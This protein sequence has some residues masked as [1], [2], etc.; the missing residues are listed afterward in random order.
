MA[1]RE[2]ERYTERNRAQRRPAGEGA[3]EGGS[4][5]QNPA[6]IMALAGLV[7]A[8]A[9]AVGF[10]VGRDK[11][12]TDT[13][14]SPDAAAT[15]AAAVTE[16]DPAG[17]DA[18]A[19]PTGADAGGEDGATGAEPAPAAGGTSDRANKY[20]APANQALDP[21]NTAY[22]AT[23][24]TD[25][26]DIELQLF[27][28]VAPKHVN[29]FVFLARQGFYD[30]LAF[31]RVEPGFVIQGGDPLGTGSGGPGYSIPAEFNSD[32]P[33]PHR[34]GTLAMARSGDPNSGGSQFYIVLA[35]GPAPT[36]LDGQYTNFGH[37]I[38][39]MDTVLAIQRGDLMN[40][41]TI[42][43]KPIAESVVTADDIRAGNL[44]E[45]LE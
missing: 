3:P 28:D 21:E 2:R 4:S 35:D 17:E 19:D 5:M 42:T 6:V 11:G 34:I 29:A 36:S 20:D 18:A 45:G 43:E 14:E 31:H 8:G 41:V 16:V 9:M 30:G 22:F 32:N 40:K 33:V 37:V 1:R 24:E 44:P 23:I 39:G 27:P 12:P 7:V 38:S 13:A 10:L 26:G 25:K 15:A